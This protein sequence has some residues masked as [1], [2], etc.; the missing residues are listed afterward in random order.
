MQ[1]IALK[2]LRFAIVPLLV[3]AVVGP[4]MARPRSGDNSSSAQEGVLLQ[5]AATTWESMA[6]MTD[7]RTGL[8]ADNINADTRVTARYTSPTNIGTY[9]GA[10]WRRA[11]SNSSRRKRRGS[12][13]R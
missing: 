9:S 10:Y 5:Y 11:T 2:H 12:A 8:T 7:A 6:A 3:F 1:R 4:A 13:S